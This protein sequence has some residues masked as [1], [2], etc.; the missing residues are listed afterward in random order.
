MLV[1]LMSHW[2]MLIVGM[3]VIMVMGMTVGQIPVGMIMVML[4]HCRAGLSSQTSA[5]LAHMD[6]LEP[7]NR[8]FSIDQASKVILS[9]SMAIPSKMQHFAHIHVLC[10]K[11]CAIR[12]R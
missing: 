8:L 10:K 3:V 9:P 11:R 5:T 6:L 12:L 4:D 1:I 7:W 2:G